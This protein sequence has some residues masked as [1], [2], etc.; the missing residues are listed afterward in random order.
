MKILTKTRKT[1]DSISK[2]EY[3]V[4]YEQV[5]WFILKLSWTDLLYCDIIKINHKIFQNAQSFIISLVIFTKKENSTR[6]N[7]RDTISYLPG[8]VVAAKSR[9]G[10]HKTIILNSN[11]HIFVAVGKLSFISF[12]FVNSLKFSLNIFILAF[13]LF[14]YEWF[15]K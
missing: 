6:S 10:R 1:S 11:K 2:F 8:S 5:L 12:F 3:D 4:M 7:K 9:V 14:I 15:H 13:Q